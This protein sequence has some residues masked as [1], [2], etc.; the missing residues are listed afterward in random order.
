MTLASER[1]AYQQR[2]EF[3]QRI[4]DAATQE[5]VEVLRLPNI[6]FLSNL[7][8]KLAKSGTHRFGIIA[9]EYDQ[10]IEAEGLAAGTR[11][12]S[13]HFV[14]DLSI[15]GAENVPQNGPLL[16]IANH[17]GGIDILAAMS[18]IP[19]DD[20]MVIALEHEMIMNIPNA[21]AHMMYLKDND[22]AQLSVIRSALRE[23]KLGKSVLIFP[24][25][26]LEPD[27]QTVPGA[28]RSIHNWSPGIGVFLHKLPEMPFIPIAISGVL[29]PDAYNLIFA[30]IRSTIKHRQR[31]AL[32]AQTL[33]RLVRPKTYPIHVKVRIGSPITKNQ[34]APDADAKE[35]ASAVKRY[36]ADYLVSL[37][38]G[39]LG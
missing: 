19:R 8:A 32:L 33:I 37:G 39:Q 20:L 21:D 9:D 30:R 6:P 26:Q 16:V 17:A 10:R 4:S 13:Q 25:G 29:N 28:I 34:L 2:P 27:P 31:T 18:G 11:W 38:L 1:G 22:P 36:M 35:T 15:E 5:A 12:F 7:V 3:V 14:T 24:A 23:L